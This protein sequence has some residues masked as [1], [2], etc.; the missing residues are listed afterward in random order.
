MSTRPCDAVRIYY[1]LIALLLSVASA[2]CGMNEGQVA[3][4]T[5]AP[6]EAFERDFVSRIYSVPRGTDEA[7]L[8]HLQACYLPVWR[9]LRDG[10]I[11]SSVDVFELHM[12]EASVPETPPWRYLMLAGLG[13]EAI[14]EDLLSAENAA[15]CAQQADDS[16]F[17]VLRIETLTCTPSSCYAMPEPTYPD[18]PEGI[19]FLIEMIAVE[20]SPELLA[21]YRDLMSTYFGPANGWLV[22]DGMMHT[23][24][25]LETTEVLYE[26]DGL[27]GGNQL[28]ISD[29]WSTQSDLDWDAWEAVYEELLRREFSVELDEVWAELPPRRDRPTEYL[30]RLVKSLCVR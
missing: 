17:S 3:P 5:S 18:A 19:D 4:Q 13:N 28:H 6:P 14:P 9:E 20:D 7:F 11:L 27:Q 30:G 15:S 26:A 29:D 21:K 22:E 12:T 1:L 23:F 2:S 24:I 8:A 16:L 25:A 10:G